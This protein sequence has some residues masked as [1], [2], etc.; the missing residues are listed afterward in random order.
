MTFFKTFGPF[1]GHP[2]TCLKT[3]FAPKMCNSVK[4]K[5]GGVKNA[6]IPLAV[7]RTLLFIYFQIFLRNKLKGTI[8]LFLK[9]ALPFLG[10]NRFKCSSKP[11][12]TFEK[13]KMGLA[14]ARMWRWISPEKE[15]PAVL[16]DWESRELLDFGWRG[17]PSLVSRRNRILNR[18]KPP[19]APRKPACEKPCRKFEYPPVAES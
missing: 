9:K 19:L 1:L 16:E 11:R 2:K 8:N 14:I 7:S 13:K 12:K 17:H 10:Q 6:N 4:S 3:S 18:S 5:K 15:K